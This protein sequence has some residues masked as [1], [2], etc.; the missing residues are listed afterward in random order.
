LGV[1]SWTLPA[2]GVTGYRVEQKIGDDDW[3]ELERWFDAGE[4][5]VTLP[6]R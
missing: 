5:S 6:R 2:G 4:R 1:L 3:I